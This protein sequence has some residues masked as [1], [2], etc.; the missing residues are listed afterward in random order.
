LNLDKSEWTNLINIHYGACLSVVFAVTVTVNSSGEKVG[1]LVVLVS[2]TAWAAF[3]A[4]LLYFFID[5]LVINVRRT[6]FTMSLPLL[7]V[8]LLYVWFLGFCVLLSKSPDSSR[9]LIIGIYVV[10]AGTYHLRAYYRRKYHNL[11]PD[12]NRAVLGMALSAAML[13]AGLYII[14]M[15]MVQVA[16]GGVDSSLPVSLI[17]VLWSGVGLKFA[18]FLLMSYIVENVRPQAPVEIADHLTG[19]RNDSI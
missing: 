7:F 19:N 16:A 13:L 9:F 14:L 17:V 4:M 18:E 5:W 11:S 1:S 2:P 12:S 15:A 10:I 3:A 6:T 8:T